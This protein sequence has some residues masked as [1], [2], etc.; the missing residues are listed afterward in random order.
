[1]P[2]ETGRKTKLVQLY[3]HPKHVKDIGDV[4]EEF[5]KRKRTFSRA[6]I[7]RY[8]GQMMVAA[9]AHID[10]DAIT[11][12]TTFKREVAKGLKKAGP[13]Y[14]STHIADADHF[15]ADD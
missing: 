12:E 11:D 1:M 15:I 2:E 5:K 9:K 3:L 6:K 10:F 8:L 14:L 7:Y 13:E 4:E